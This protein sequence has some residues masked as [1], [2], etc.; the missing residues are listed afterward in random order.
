MSLQNEFIFYLIF[1]LF[2]DRTVLFFQGHHIKEQ[3]EMIFLNM[4]HN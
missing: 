3:I 4:D 2:F 1:K